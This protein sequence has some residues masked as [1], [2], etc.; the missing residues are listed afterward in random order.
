MGFTAVPQELSTSDEQHATLESHTQTSVSLGT[1]GGSLLPTADELAVY[2]IKTNKAGKPTG[3]KE[4]IHIGRKGLGATGEIFAADDL[5]LPHLDLASLYSSRA[6]VFDKL[7]T[8]LQNLVTFVLLF[9]NHRR[10]LTPDFKTVCKWYGEL[11]GVRPDNIA[12]HGKRLKE[13]GILVNDTTL[14]PLWQ[15][16][17]ARP[18]D[19]F[20]EEFEA[21]NR[22]RFAAKRLVESWS[23]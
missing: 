1:Y 23:S 20:T 3:V 8:E 11:K 14:G 16:T 13:L 7:R 22:R 17:G 6:K 10:G 5:K 4:L 15:K 18:R 9:R 2:S 12:R 19:V 21:D